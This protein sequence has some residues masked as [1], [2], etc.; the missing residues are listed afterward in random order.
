[1]S[2]S[3]NGHGARVG[4][5]ALQGAFAAHARVLAELGAHPVEVLADHHGDPV[6]LRQDRVMA[7]AFHPELTDDGRLHAA[8]VELVRSTS[9]EH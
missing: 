1:M 6:L 8:F 2:R 9:E 7:A 5:L 4:V 3:V